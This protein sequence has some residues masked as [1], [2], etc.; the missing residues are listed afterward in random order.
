MSNNGD[1]RFRGRWTLCI[2]GMS[3]GV[4][5]TIS[6]VWMLRLSMPAIRGGGTQFIDVWFPLEPKVMFLVGA[7]LLIVTAIAAVARK[8]TRKPFH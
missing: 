3:G 1:E 8:L 5:L 2:L 6:V 7:V 4:C